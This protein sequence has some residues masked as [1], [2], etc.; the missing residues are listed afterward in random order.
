MNVTFL[1][2]TEEVVGR[3]ILGGTTFSVCAYAIFL[4][5]AIYDYQE[6]KPIEEKSPVDLLVKD[7]MHSE[8]WFLYQVC[9]IEIISLFTPPITSDVTYL[10]SHIS[11]FLL[12]FQQIS[13]LILLYIQHAYVFHPDEC[14]KVDVSIMRQMSIIW[15]FT[16]TVFSI[17][18]SCLVPSPEV[19]LAYQMLTKGA[20]YN[21]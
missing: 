11:V 6:E 4:C 12:N 9:L 21:R 5:N 8:F 17:S 7:L 3:F 16:L 14:A 10:V 1:N 18:I 2:S 20:D 15:K 19:P 13:T